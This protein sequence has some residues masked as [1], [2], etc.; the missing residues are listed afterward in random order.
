MRIGVVAVNASLVVEIFSLDEVLEGLLCDRLVH[1]RWYARNVEV[2]RKVVWRPCVSED[3][4]QAEQM[5]GRNDDHPRTREMTGVGILNHTTRD[6]LETRT[7][8]NLRGLRTPKAWTRGQTDCLR[9]PR[10]A[11]GYMLHLLREW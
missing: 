1:C 11:G 3:E 7:C 8:H 10:G 2:R 4:M 9:P 5:H 6:M